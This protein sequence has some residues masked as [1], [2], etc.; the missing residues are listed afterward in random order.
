MTRV[1]RESIEPLVDPGVNLVSDEA[2][3]PTLLNNHFSSVFTVKKTVE[4]LRLNP[5]QAIA[6]NLAGA[7]L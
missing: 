4:P 3:M 6:A 1:C 7:T 5:A 2:G